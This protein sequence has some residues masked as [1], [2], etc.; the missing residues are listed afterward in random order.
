[1]SLKMVKRPDNSQ[2]IERLQ[3]LRGERFVYFPNPGNAG[4]SLIAASTYQLFSDLN[5]EYDLFQDVESFDG[6]TVVL[7]GG[8]NFIPQYRAIRAAI[9]KCYRHAA[10]IVLLPHTVRG[11]EDVV[12]MLG[13]N[14]DI[15][16]RDVIS[17]QH[18]LECRSAA[19][20][21]LG[22]DMAFGLDVQRFLQDED[23]CRMAKA[24]IDRKIPKKRPL[25]QMFSTAPVR[26]FFRNDKEKTSR[27]VPKSSLDLSSLFK[28][29]VQP[30]SAQVSAAALFLYLSDPLEVHTDRLHIGIAAS[31]LGKRVYL[32]DNS[33]GKNAGVYRHSIH[34]NF[35]DVQLI[36]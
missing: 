26:F 8:G 15:F 32:Y 20:A 7:G 24:L 22:H 3:R 5:L 21:F 10:A 16:C 23:L 4:D 27:I 12:S 36:P 29:D 1:M 14:A 11:N 13:S 6:R 18:V 28:S 9:L 31:L 17:Y 33:Y 34:S 2:L 30:G 19:R 25:V 35:P